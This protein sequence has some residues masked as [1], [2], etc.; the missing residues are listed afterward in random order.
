MLDFIIMQLPLFL[1]VLLRMTSFFVIAPV[2]S[3]RGIPNRYKVAFGFFVTIAA[4]PVVSA[5]KPIVFNSFYFTLLIKEITIGVLMGFIAA[6]IIYTVQVSGAFIDFQMGF[7]IANLV[8]PQTGA[9]VPVISQFKYL[10]TI[11]FFV[12]IDGHHLLLDGMMKSFEVIKLDQLISLGNESFATF[13]ITLFSTMFITAA[14]ISL[15]IVGA[16]FLIDVGLGIIAKTVPQVNVF[17]VG[18]PLKIFAG[19]I[20]LLITI[21]VFFFLLQSIISNVVHNLGEVLKLIGV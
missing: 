11:L 3:Y 12:T 15:P 7:A 20:L 18:L 13:M 4:L 1:L 21:P 10:L 2:F 16:L 9:Q 5:T 14:Q 8:D 19:F 17:V 6:M